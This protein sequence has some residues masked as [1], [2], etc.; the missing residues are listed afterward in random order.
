MLFWV[1]SDGAW[2]CISRYYITVLILLTGTCLFSCEVHIAFFLNC[3]RFNSHRLICYT[4]V[5]PEQVY[6]ASPFQNHSSAFLVLYQ[7]ISVS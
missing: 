4:Q 1:F 2:Y 6:A 5:S 7:Y 3:G